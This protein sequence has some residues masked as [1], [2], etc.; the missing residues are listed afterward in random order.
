[1]EA[2]A[3]FPVIKPT[4]RWT[5]TWAFCCLCN[6]ACSPALPRETWDAWVPATWEVVSLPETSKAEA[7][8]EV[9]Q[10]HSG[11]SC[12][13]QHFF[14]STATGDGWGFEKGRKKSLGLVWPI[15]FW[16]LQCLCEVGYLRGCITG[17]S[18]SVS[19][20][21]RLPLAIIY[22]SESFQK[23]VPRRSAISICLG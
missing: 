5:H 6:R 10:K 2:P 17:H 3:G 8:A 23:Q 1:M 16:A 19:C 14:S 22:T 13:P 21:R 12:Q 9:K 15:C 11:S 20:G 4:S 18:V 7:V